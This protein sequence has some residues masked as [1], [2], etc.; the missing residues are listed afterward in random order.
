MFT[1]DVPMTKL[2]QAFL[3][4]TE[5]EA[6]MPKEHKC[7]RCGKCS[8][9]CPVNLMPFELNQYAVYSKLAEFRANNGMDCIE[10]GSCSFVCPSKRHLAQSIRAERRMV[11]AD[12]K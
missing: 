3:A 4:F 10:C 1:L 6:H 5:A 11:L 7:I 8:D 2:S 12:K 9:I